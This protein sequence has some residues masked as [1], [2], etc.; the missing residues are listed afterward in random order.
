M[1][2][3]APHLPPH[4]A[5]HLEPHLEGHNSWLSKVTSARILGHPLV[6]SAM[7][8]MLILVG[9]LWLQNFAKPLSEEL[10]QAHLSSELVG[11]KSG[12]SW[13]PDIYRPTE[14]KEKMS[15]THQADKSRAEQYR[16]IIDREDQIQPMLLKARSHM[17]QETYTG[18]NADNAWQSYQDILNIEADHKLARSGQA[19]IVGL[20][21]SN[22]E[23]A[24]DEFEYEEAEQWLTQLDRISPKAPFQAALRLRIAEQ[25]SEEIADQ[26]AALR[27]VERNTLLNN[28]L[29]DAKDAMQVSPPKLRAAYDLYQRALELE[30]NNQAALQGLNTIHSTRSAYAEQA[31]AEKNFP[32]ARLQIDRLREIVA[33]TEQLKKLE[34]ALS[35]AQ[36]SQHESQQKSAA[37]KPAQD[38][39]TQELKKDPAMA[40][41]P[42][43]APAIPAKRSPPVADQTTSDSQGVK[44]VEIQVLTNQ[45]KPTPAI[46]EKAQSL[47]T[48]INAYYQGDYNTAF[49]S[50]HPLAEANSARAQFRLGIMYYQGRTVVK[51]E[52]IARQW[53]ARAMPAILRSAQSGQAWAQ[54]DLGTAYEL[55]IGVK[56]D[57]TRAA[58]WYQKSAKQG[59]AGAQTNLGVF[60]GTGKGVKYDRKAAIYWLKKAASQG[61]KIAQDNL[62]IL[63]AR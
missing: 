53:I 55:G 33:D 46:N 37:P 32:E 25:I 31:I 43:A 20:L 38:G 50:L 21:Q 13:N 8:G 58:S 56:Q 52:D 57:V 1:T 23:Y 59:Y 22:A 15:I 45:D 54:A 44:T 47:A 12:N 51:N 48:G 60:Y 3:Q 19:Q 40:P 17:E 7:T 42:E 2:H 4:L 9:Y 62:K 30:E 41:A 26:E 6:W 11:S 16:D 35:N 49:A 24:T 39:A 18:N 29:Q 28:A 63:N 5:P 36:S 10:A 27:Q 61:D 34:T 14:T